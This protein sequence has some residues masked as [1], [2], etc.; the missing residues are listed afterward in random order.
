MFSRSQVQESA[1][2]HGVLAR[3]HA[4]CSGSTILE[5][6]FVAGPFIALILAI[7]QTALIFFSNQLLETA[8]QSAARQIMT[9]TVQQANA[10]A[11]LTQA[12]FKTLTC[13][14]L[15]DFMQCANLT[16]DVTKG[17]DFASANTGSP[18]ITYSGST[19]TF[20]N[21]YNIGDDNDVVVV[22][23]MYP[24][25]VVGAPGL[26]L[27]SLQNGKFLLMATSVAMTEPYK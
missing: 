7:L 8:A 25:S 2:H 3:L 17:T 19:P 21:R 23:L 1:R 22:R 26:S 11:G 4:D 9:G 15:P 13:S 5:F 12:E 6:A 20:P 18:A 16:V 14:K 10:G 24:W 27:G